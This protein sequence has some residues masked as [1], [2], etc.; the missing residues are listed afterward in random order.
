MLNLNRIVITNIF[1]TLIII[2]GVKYETYGQLL[3]PVS[4]FIVKVDSFKVA[5]KPIPFDQKFTMLIATREPQNVIEALVYPTQLNSDKEPI[6]KG[7]T[8]L[9]L[10]TIPRVVGGQLE[11]N[12]K[13]LPPNF[14]FDFCLI[15]KF[16]GKKYDELLTYVNFAVYHS[17]VPQKSSKVDEMEN[18]FFAFYSKTNA[19]PPGYVVPAAFLYDFLFISSC[20]NTGALN[21]CDNRSLNN[22]FSYKITDAYK[23]IFNITTTVTYP[24]ANLSGDLQYVYQQMSSQK[25]ANLNLPKLIR[26]V[27]LTY[28]D[29]LMEGLVN[30]EYNYQSQIVEKYDIK[31]RLTNFNSN[32][33]LINSLLDTV[34]ALK[35]LLPADT[36]INNVCTY[37]KNCSSELNKNKKI[38]EDNYAI[39]KRDLQTAPG[40]SYAE[41]L[42]HTTTNFKDFTTKS[43][44]LFSPQIGISAFQVNYQEKGFGLIPKLT[45]GINI[46]FRSIDKNLDRATIPNK[47]LAHYLSGY[48]GVTFGK[49]RDKEFDN[50]LPSNSLLVGL[51][52][53]LS[54][55]FY[56]S[57]GGTVYRQ[58][59]RNPVI[60]DYHLQFG[61]YISLLLDLDI[62]KGAT[63]ITSILFK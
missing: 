6:I 34:E 7:G 62:T 48:V 47:K 15:K 33:E 23:S 63:T 14:N 2:L 10:K 20:D 31:S 25:F 4:P 44:S 38:T 1:I 55:V 40:I 54:K 57:A 26:L 16:E 17:V 35:F 36:R 29:E 39:I 41:W 32:Y 56:L 37:L 28:M 50:F 43:G 60:N 30:F 52:Y 9:F 8:K 45:T 53:R 13:A 3:Q 12:F 24:A 46:N 59:Y 58:L 5:D 42:N 51:N 21:D 18:K 11:V 49:F 19:A 61:A 22:V 27:D